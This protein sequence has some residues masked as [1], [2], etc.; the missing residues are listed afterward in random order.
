MKRTLAALTV[1]AFAL[2]AN[3]QRSRQEIKDNVNLAGSN[4]V[5]YR[6][7]QKTLTASPRGYE[8][9]Y[10]SH[11]GRHGSR[12]LIGTADY[13]K[14][15]FALMRADSLNRLTAAGRE[16]LA[17]VREIRQEASMRDGELTLLGARQHRDI[18]QRMYQ[19]FPKV[20]AGA[21]HIDARSTIV[22]RCILSMENALQELVAI[23]PKLRISHD[24]SHHDMYY[25]NDGHSPY[26]KR[27]DTPEAR[28]ALRIFNARHTDYSHLA[29]VLF[30]GA[31][32]EGE[33]DMTELGNRLM[34][35]A[36]NVQS[37]ELRHRLTLWDIFTEDEI[38]NHW[39]RTNAFWYMYYGPSRQT[40]GAGMYM[41]TNLLHNIIATAD[42]CIRLPHPG[43]TLRYGHEVNVM[44]LACL[45]NLNGYGETI[46]NLEEL[47]DK[48]WYNYDIYPMGCNIQMVFYKPEKGDVRQADILVKVLFNEDEATLPVTTDCA[49]YY[50]WKDVRA[51][52]LNKIQ[53]K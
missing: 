29:K 53:G 23:N 49:P 12:Y 31:N 25:M 1:M 14:P 2:M 28:E 17:K 52:Y 45:L 24:A 10:I 43:V 41:Q 46:D 44:P 33:V 26:D 40:E 39:L 34:T 11:Y 30:N 5:A 27:R 36:S 47:D 15:Y 8:P 42:S 35:L 7:P 37:T 18:A 38:Y 32:Y 22:I 48:G 4:Y 51:Y 19:R 9:F 6:G 13:D 21:A 3:A 50:H 20:F 16:V